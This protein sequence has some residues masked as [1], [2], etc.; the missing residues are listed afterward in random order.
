MKTDNKLRAF[1]ALHK[2]MIRFCVTFSPSLSLPPSYLTLTMGLSFVDIF[3][4]TASIV[5]RRRKVSLS[6]E[7]VR[8][9][10]IP[11]GELNGVNTLAGWLHS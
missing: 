4:V 1:L 9:V 5:N 3:V 10:G 6:R 2:A 7:I 11:V 8:V